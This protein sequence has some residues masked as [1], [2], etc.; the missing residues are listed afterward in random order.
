MKVLY[1]A[2]F[3]GHWVQL[4]RIAKG[5]SFSD[6]VFISTKSVKS[7]DK[8]YIIKD[9]NVSNF[10]I[11]FSEFLKVYRIIKEE[12][13]AWVL[14]T[15]AAPGLLVIFLASIVGKKTM[16]VDSIANSKKLSLSGK[17]AMYF[18]DITLSQWEDVAAK[19]KKVEYIGSLL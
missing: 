5:L 6:E 3:G 13:P 9:F 4:N 7:E 10:Y 12:D 18:A 11:G 19:N 8:V 16:W 17:L 1:A 14:S 15:G 2:S